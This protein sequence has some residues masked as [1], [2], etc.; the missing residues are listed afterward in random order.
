MS[1]LDYEDRE[2]GVFQEG[3][4]IQAVPGLSLKDQE[5]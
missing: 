2:E 1:S 3:Y 4:L 5:E